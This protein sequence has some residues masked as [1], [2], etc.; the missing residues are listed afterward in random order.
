MTKLSRATSLV[1][2]VKGATCKAHLGW[3]DRSPYEDAHPT[4]SVASYLDGRLQGR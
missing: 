4:S 1:A 2:I 3:P